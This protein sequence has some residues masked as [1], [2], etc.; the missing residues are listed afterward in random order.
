MEQNKKPKILVVDDVPENRKIIATIINRETD[1]TVQLA[2]SGNAVLELIEEDIPE[3]ILLDIMMPGMDGYDVANSLKQNPRT[4]NIPILFITAVDDPESIIKAFDI[5]GVDYITKPFNKAELLARVNAHLSLKLMQDEL[6]EKNAL[7]EDRSLHLTKLVDEQTAK[8]KKTT[9][10]LV[11]AL[12]NA[13]FFND[14]DTGNHIRRVSEYSSFLAEQYKADSNFINKIRLY[15]SLHDVGKV[16]LSD[17]LLKKPGRYTEDEFTQMQQHVMIGARMLENEEIDE[18]AR[19]IAL[20]HH[21]WWNGTGYISKLKG[22]EIPLEARIVSLADVY[23]ALS[24][25]RVYKDAFT[26]EEVDKIIK[27]SRGTQFE[28]ALVDIYLD[29]QKDFTEIRTTFPD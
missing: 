14:N 18:M 26:P 19:N 4:K 3:L 24:N 17:A 27:E 2:G 22:E 12:E 29:N 10:A 7:L 11:T 9:I 13:N 16:G 23:D 28:P 6:S 25:K 15:A 8:I 21:E 20:Y 1:Y 5:G